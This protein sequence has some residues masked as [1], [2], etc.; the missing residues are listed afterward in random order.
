MIKKF[1]LSMQT[2]E[3]RRKFSLDLL[4]DIV[5]GFLFACG[6]YTFAKM[7]GFSPG[8]VSGLALIINKLTDLPIGVTTLILNVPLILLSYKFIGKKFLFKT[9]RSMLVCTFFVDVI[10]PNT[11]AY[12][13]DP[14]LAAIYY[15][16]FVGVGLALIYMRGS[17]T[18]GTDFLVM[19]VKSKYPYFSIGT[20][21]MFINIFVI[22]LGWPVFGNVDSVLYGL[23]SM[24]SVSFV[25]D[26]VMYGAN[27]RKMLIIICNRGEEIANAIHKKAHRG[28]TYIKAMGT[29]SK[30][31]KD[32]LLCACNKA[33]A[34]LVTTMVHE[35]DPTAFVMVSET[36]E[37]F[38]EG[39]IVKK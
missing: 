31:D 4:C 36:S 16:I 3:G 28:S 7:A 23:I 20:V 13:G 38:G 37:V 26:R 25:V 33:Q 5:G 39:F 34:Y 19:T 6:V 32:V 17:S 24:V 18:G 29:Y 9:I 10:F 11:P 2:K 30:D 14:L 1:L 12:T 8:G 22:L 35:I 27:A 21:A 15:G